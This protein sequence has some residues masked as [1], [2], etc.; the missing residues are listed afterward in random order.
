MGFDSVVPANDWTAENA[1]SNKTF[2]HGVRS[3]FSLTI[4]SLTSNALFTECSEKI[5]QGN[6]RRGMPEPLCEI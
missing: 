2:C 1:I 3:V 4:F 6:N 5:L